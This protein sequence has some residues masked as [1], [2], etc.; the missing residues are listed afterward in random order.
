MCTVLCFITM[1]ICDVVVCIGLEKP[2]LGMSKM[3]ENLHGM[4]S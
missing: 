1:M 2:I 4:A 3:C